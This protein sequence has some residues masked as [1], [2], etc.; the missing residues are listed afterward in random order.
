MTFALF[1]ADIISSMRFRLLE[2][3]A[4]IYFAVS[5][6]EFLR[7]ETYIPLLGNEFIEELYRRFLLNRI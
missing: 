3:N 1:Y 4:V 2:E 6:K 7:S 5:G